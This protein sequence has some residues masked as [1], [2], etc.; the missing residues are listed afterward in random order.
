MAA[1]HDGFLKLTGEK[2]PIHGPSDGAALKRR[3]SQCQE[4]GEW[5]KVLRV[6]EYALSGRD[7]WFRENPPSLKLILGDTNYTRLL[8]RLAMEWKSAAR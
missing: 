5:Q 7:R 4:E 8:G 2:P 6:I 1:Y 3:L